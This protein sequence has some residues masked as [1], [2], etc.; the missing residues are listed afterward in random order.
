MAKLHFKQPLLQSSVSRD[1]L[2]II[3]I[4]WFGAQEAFLFIIYNIFMEADPWYFFSG[5]FQWLISFQINKVF[6]VTLDHF[7]AS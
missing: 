2:E 6:T 3:L 1:P 5:F 7:N 4:C